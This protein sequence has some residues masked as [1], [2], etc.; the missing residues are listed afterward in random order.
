MRHALMQGHDG[1]RDAA[2]DGIGLR[3]GESAKGELPGSSA[4]AKRRS[5]RSAPGQQQRRSHQAHH[6]P[7]ISYRS[8][9]NVSGVR[10]DGGLRPLRA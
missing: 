6:V 2:E 8:G 5:R 1:G 9:C 7:M 4:G 10:P 3:G